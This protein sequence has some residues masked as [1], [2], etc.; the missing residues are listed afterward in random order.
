[1]RKTSWGNGIQFLLVMVSRILAAQS[2]RYIYTQMAVM[3]DL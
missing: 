3:I 1:M 2:R